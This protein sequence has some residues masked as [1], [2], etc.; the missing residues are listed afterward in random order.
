[1]HVILVYTP[2]PVA[3]TLTISLTRLANNR[4]YYF[5]PV[6]TTLSFES[7]NTFCKDHGMHLVTINSNAEN[8]LIYAQL[9]LLGL[10][11]APGT[12]LGYRDVTGAGTYKWV[13][14]KVGP[15][16]TFFRNNPTPTQCAAYLDGNPTA[17]WV[18]RP[19]NTQRAFVCELEPPC[20]LV[21]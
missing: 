14:P 20:S 4:L 10:D 12:W 15:T 9:V 16:P 13:Q 6:G 18:T 17:S 1:M 21:L 8:T 11:V 19:C 5:P 3:P 7:A 2:S